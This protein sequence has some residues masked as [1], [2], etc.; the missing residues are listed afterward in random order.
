MQQQWVPR[1]TGAH[2]ETLS[3]EFKVGRAARIT[4]SRALLVEEM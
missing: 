3:P 4:R 2:E 1:V